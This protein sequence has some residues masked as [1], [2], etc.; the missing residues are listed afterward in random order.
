[1]KMS[2]PKIKLG[3]TG[4]IGSGKSYVCRL[5]EERGVPLFNCDREAGWLM[6]HHEVLRG[7]LKLLLGDAVYDDAGMLVKSVVRQYLCQ[8]PE[9]ASRI[10][11][12]VHPLV[13]ERLSA[14]ADAHEESVLA[15]ECA[16]LF[17][18]GFNQFV[19]YTVAVAAPL[20]LRIQR[21]MERDGLSEEKVRG[22]M[23]LQLPEDEKQRRA[24]RI[25]RNDGTV[26]LH[27]QLDDLLAPF[28]VF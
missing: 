10:N 23:A 28:K 24:D 12:L 5:L 17:E 9:A 16:L 14:W 22:M 2:I 3:V 18:S 1:M 20:E 19:D 6:V 21:V 13:R 11:A 15:V 25:L 4:G 27:S 26:S 8:G 7:Q